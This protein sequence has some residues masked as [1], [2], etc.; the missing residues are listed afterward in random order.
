[1]KSLRSLLLSLLIVSLLFGCV[2]SASSF[3]ANGRVSVGELLPFGQYNGETVEWKILEIKGKEALLISN[4]ILDSHAFHENQEG[5]TW[6]QSDLRAWL[7]D[8]FL[9]TAF[10]AEEQEAIIV[11]VVDNGEAQRNPY[12]DMFGDPIVTDETEDKVFV[13]SY[14][15]AKKLFKSDADRAADIA[16]SLYIDSNWWLRSPGFVKFNLMYVDETGSIDDSRTMYCSSDVGVRPVIRVNLIALS[17]L[18]PDVISFDETSAEDEEFAAAYKVYID[19]YRQFG[20][21]A[22][23]SA[24]SP[25]KQERVRA[26]VDGQ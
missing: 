22:D 12:W 26:Y 1:M 18:M 4:T 10:T 3:A 21:F 19:L 13:L 7:N 17:E 15:E 25:E 23:L 24:L 2:G 20:K 16:P 6:D 8:E 9:N 14:A 5:E 11:S